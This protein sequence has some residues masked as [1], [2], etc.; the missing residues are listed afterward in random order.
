[1]QK[2]NQFY[3]MSGWV[4]VL[5]VTEDEMAEAMGIS[6]PELHEAIHNNG[7]PYH[8]YPLA[9]GG[10]YQF[11]P[12]QLESNVARWKC[13]Q[14]GGHEWELDHFYDEWGGKA[15]YECVNCPANKYD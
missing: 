14:N 11:L 8:A 15:V 10:K 13:I 7:I 1:M 3:Q 6:V 5:I 12:E 2:V 4:N 9:T